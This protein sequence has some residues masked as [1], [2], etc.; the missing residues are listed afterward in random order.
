MDTA[1]AREQLGWRPAY[2]TRDTLDALVQ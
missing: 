2:D 1:K